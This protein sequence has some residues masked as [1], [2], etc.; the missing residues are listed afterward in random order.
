[1]RVRGTDRPL[2]EPHGCF[3]EQVAAGRHDGAAHLRQVRGDPPARGQSLRLHHRKLVHRCGDPQNGGNYLE[4][5]FLLGFNSNINLFTQV[6][7]L[8]GNSDNMRALK[9]TL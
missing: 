2:S 1:M 7:D 6:I 8:N 9:V 4:S 5:A 3:A